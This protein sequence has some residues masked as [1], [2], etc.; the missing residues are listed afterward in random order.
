[1]GPRVVEGDQRH[2]PN[3]GCLPDQMPTTEGILA[4][5]HEQHRSISDYVIANSR[6]DQNTTV[7]MDKSCPQDS[8]N[9]MHTSR[10]EK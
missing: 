4:K 10:Q 1:M 3:T 8:S 2:C 7:E 9:E 6:D 5:H